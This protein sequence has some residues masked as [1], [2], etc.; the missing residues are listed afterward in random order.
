MR[1]ATYVLDGLLENDTVLDIRE[2]T[3][4]THGATEHL[5]GLC[6]LLGFAFMPRFKDVA[7]QTL[8]KFDRS[9]R[10]GRL[11]PFFDGAADVALIRE[12]WDALVRVAASLKN[13]TSPAHV[14]LARLAVSSERLAKALQALGRI[15]KTTHVL[16]Y[17]HDAKLR[18]RVQLQLNRG[19]SRHDLARRLFFANRGVFRSGDYA[20]I[21]NK[22]SALSVLSNAVLVWNT[23]RI[24]AIV[25]ELAAAGHTVRP[26]DL[27]R[28]SP[29]LDSHV[30]ATG[31][32]HFDRA[33]SAR[34][35]SKRPE[36]SGPQPLE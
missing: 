28:V 13:R 24:G 2:H 10:Y 15:L 34:A 19:E 36:N 21:M 30:I 22:V 12:Q 18:S 4:D 25:D 20:E 26:E 17:L 33:I 27:A 7:D 35:V 5:F 23:V 29:L 31:S 3:T 6:H 1:E 14:V 16:R 9:A 11:D 8:Y 32:Y